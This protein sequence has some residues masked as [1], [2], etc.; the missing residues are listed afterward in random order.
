VDPQPTVKRLNLQYNLVG[1]TSCIGDCNFLLGTQFENSSEVGVFAR[2]TN[3]YCLVSPSST[4]EQKHFQRTFE[5]ELSAHIPVIPTTIANC[6]TIG[7]MTVGNTR[8]LLLPNTTS[9]QEMMHIRNS[10][11]DKVHVQRVEEKLSALGNVIACNDHVA[12]VHPDLDRVRL[13]K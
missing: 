2:L 5:D 13:M 4:F 3:G 7:R 12:I 11:P 6:R 8:G 9:D 1:Q 10:L